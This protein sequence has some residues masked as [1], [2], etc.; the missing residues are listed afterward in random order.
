MASIRASLVTVNGK[1]FNNLKRRLVLTYTHRFYTI[2][3][4][5]L[6]DGICDVGNLQFLSVS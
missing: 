1:L 5:P 2:Q 6:D 3:G 4:C